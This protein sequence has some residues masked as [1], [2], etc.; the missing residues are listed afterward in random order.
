M[1]TLY[2]IRHGQA[3]FG[4]EN[5]DALSPLGA[6]QSY[7]LGNFLASRGIAFDAL[8][9]GT[10]ARHIETAD[11]IMRA[12]GEHAIPLPEA[13][14][15]EE[16]NEYDSHSI[17]KGI[18]PELLEK[19]E[20]DPSDVARIFSDRKAFQRV[21]EKTMLAWVKGDCR[22]SLTSWQAFVVNVHHALDAIMQRDGK[23]KTVAIITSG[24]PISA[25]IRQA[26]LLSDD[27]T[28]RVTWQIKNASFSKF[29]CTTESLMLES[30]NEVPH[31]ESA[32]LIT[33]R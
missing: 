17:L 5:Y 21:F 32:D 8:Y 18:V 28:M 14:R 16:L 33:Y 10:L 22:A 1:S 11:S 12:Y 4:K 3:S 19:G 23:G 25:A 2:F 15:M 7:A 6:R 24:G 30:F 31:L 29:K 26:L 20:V 13:S 9:T 27:I